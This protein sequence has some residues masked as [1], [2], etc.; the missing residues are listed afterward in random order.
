MKGIPKMNVI[1]IYKT[2]YG[3][4]RDYAEYIAEKL[5]TKAVEA[6]TVKLSDLEKYDTVVYGGGLYAEVI[7]GVTLIT[8]NINKLSDKKIAVF[9]TGLTPPD[10]CEYYDGYVVKRNFKNGV[11][12]NVKIFNYPGKMIVSELSAV[13]RT[14]IKALKKMMSAKENPTAS[15]K[16]LIELCDADGD[17]SDMSLTSELIEYVTEGK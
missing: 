11:P 15:E 3:S 12:S 9:T 2:K 17:F 1:V 5:G 14:A 8:K 7:N 4:T 6:K 13:H 16:M 10:Y